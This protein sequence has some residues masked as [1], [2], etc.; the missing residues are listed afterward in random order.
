MPP[1]RSATARHSAATSGVSTGSGETTLS[2]Q[3][4]RPGCSDSA[5][6]L[7][8]EPADEPAGEPD[9][10]PHAGLR[11]VVECSGTR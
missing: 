10:D 9:P 6:P 2:T 1:Y 8:Q 7:E 3:A 11:G 5:D 4:S